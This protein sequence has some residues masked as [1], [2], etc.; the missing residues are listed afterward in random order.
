[1]IALTAAS[2]S[3]APTV[4]ISSS[5]MMPPAQLKQAKQQAANKRTHNANTHVGQYAEAPALHDQACQ[6]TGHTTNYQ[7]QN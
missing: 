4:A 7:K 1:M 2:N 3:T 5:P 6:P